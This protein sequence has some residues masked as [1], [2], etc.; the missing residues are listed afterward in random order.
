MIFTPAPIQGAFVIDL[1]LRIDERG[2]FARAWCAAEF[3]RA[4]LD[5]RI[6]QINTARSTVAGTLRGLH[7]QLPPHAEAK[8]VRCTQ[9]AVF[10]VVVDLRPASPSFRRWHG[11][12]LDAAG[13]RMLYIPEGCAHGYITLCA[14]SDLMYQASVPYAPK[15]AKGLRYDDPAFAIV[16]PRPV[17]LVSQADLNWPQFGSAE[18]AGWQ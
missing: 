8:L 3:A 17:E 11:V 16:W 1:E 15:H 2:Q 10:D 7:F 9:G 6:A 12:L 4:G 14:N 13:G 18:Y 5:V